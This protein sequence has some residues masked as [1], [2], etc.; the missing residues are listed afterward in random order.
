MVLHSKFSMLVRPDSDVEMS[1]FAIGIQPTERLLLDAKSRANGDRSGTRAKCVLSFNEDITILITHVPE[2]ECL[3]N[4]W[5]AGTVSATR[6]NVRGQSFASCVM[7]LRNQ[8][9]HLLSNV[10]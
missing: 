7:P 10:Q 1:T 4:P 9:R 5:T 3:E 6:R 8:R 2:C